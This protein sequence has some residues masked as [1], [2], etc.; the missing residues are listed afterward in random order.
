MFRSNHLLKSIVCL[1]LVL[2][3]IASVALLGGCGSSK[4]TVPD[5][6]GLTK[7]E[8]EAKVAELG[9]V[10]NVQRERYS[11]KNP[12]GSI[13]AMI[14]KVGDTVEKDG[15]IRVVGSLGEGVEVPNISVLTGKEG[16]NL[17][18]KV[19]LNPIVV[20]E[21]SD[22]VEEGN[23]ISYTD[24]GQTIPKGADVTITVSKGPES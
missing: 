14:T 6:V 7:E 4:I 13:D 21:F 12:A 15:E 22:E 11:K 8:A 19:G 9:A 5:L 20:E 2:M 17:V 24:G 3:C 23:I 1:A 10:L 16:A 18:S